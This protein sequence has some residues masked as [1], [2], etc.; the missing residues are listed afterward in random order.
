MIRFNDQVL[1]EMRLN[2]T[3]PESGMEWK[4]FMTASGHGIGVVVSKVDTSTL[5]PLL[6]ES[7]GLSWS[8][9]TA[10][11]LWVE[12]YGVAK[13]LSSKVNQ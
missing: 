13:G 8:E 12:V 9:V 4:V 11:R 6:K 2:E 7:F 10:E 5:M 3:M 1:I